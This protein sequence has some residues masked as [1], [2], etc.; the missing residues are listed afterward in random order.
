MSGKKKKTENVKKFPTLSNAPKS[1][2][3]PPPSPLFDKTNPMELLAR[4][5]LLSMVFVFPLAIGPQKYGNITHYKNS[6]F[7]VLA[8]L[9]LCSVIVAMIIKVISTP[10]ER[11]KVELPK[12]NVPDYAVLI[13]WGFLFI[14]TLL[15]PYKEVAF[16]GQ[17]VRNDGFI[18]QSFYVAVYF[19][20]S[21]LLKLRKFDLN[22]YCCGAT[23]VAGL[24]MFHFFGVDL[25][26]TGF[27]KPNWESGLLF[28]GPMG[29]INLTS[30]FVTAALVLASGIYITEQQL[31]FDRNG[32][33]TL[34]C[35]ALMLWAELNLNTDAGIV[36][37]GVV[38]LTW[39]LEGKFGTTGWLLVAAAILFG[40]AAVFIGC[41][42]ASDS[43]GRCKE[44]IDLALS[45]RRL[46]IGSL[47]IDGLAVVGIFVASFFA[48]KSQKSGVLYEFGQM[49]Y[50]GNFS[51]KF[52]HNRM[53]TWKRTLKL[54]GNKPVFG[55]GPDSFC[56]VFNEVYGEESKKFFGGRNL[57]KAHNEF[58]QL[59]ICS[60][61][62]G[63]GAFLAF[64]GSLITKAS[65]I[66]AAIA[67]LLV[68]PGETGNHPFDAAEAETEICEGMLAEYSGAPLGVFKLSHAIK[69]LTMT[70]LFVMLFFGGIGAGVAHLVALIGL[71]G[72]AAT[73]VTILLDVLV[74]FLLCVLVTAVG[75][76][77]VHAVTA[78]LKIEQ[79]FKYYWTVVSALA[80]LSLVLVWYGL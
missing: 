18:I 44:K 7:Y 23:I 49:V 54:V 36:A 56:T 47:V 67:F 46:L 57:D 8:A 14:S 39:I 24:V 21:H 38:L 15:S 35:V 3:S 58:L 45:R 12:F 80:L 2:K 73:A 31:P 10:T 30:Y 41:D 64:I 22:V 78:R 63:L 27:S 4:V 65:L 60:G 68:I 16:N 34:S 6:V 28:M 61:F 66:P 51:D 71:T 11:F 74:L 5:F 59:L 29:N 37:L 75:I 79:I 52:G 1:R 70:S 55:S 77:L 48:A 19:L 26:S 76:S 33:V 13:Y 40:A 72:G 50:H 25:L 42:F 17:G 69:M 20:I 43:V 53:F 9:G 32:A 62:T